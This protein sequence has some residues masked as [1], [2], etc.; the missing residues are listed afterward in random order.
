MTMFVL[1]AAF[2]LGGAFSKKAFLSFFACGLS[3]I[4]AI[5]SGNVGAPDGTALYAD[6]VVFGV[7]MGLMS[8]VSAL[9]GIVHVVEESR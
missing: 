7:I 4:G 2:M 5:L 9:I 1:S 8:A 6:Y 3:A